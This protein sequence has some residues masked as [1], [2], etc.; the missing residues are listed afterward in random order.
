M[1][2]HK[3]SIHYGL[4]TR[5][6]GLL[7]FRAGDC[8]D[9]EKFFQS[10]D[11]E[12]FFNKPFIEDQLVFFFGASRSG[13]LPMLVTSKGPS[14]FIFGVKACHLCEFFLIC[15]CNLQRVL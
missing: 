3:R 14:G 11:L 2:T 9:L 10:W 8:L 4:K 6:G 5:K 1:H 7:G 15:L 13:P 12:N